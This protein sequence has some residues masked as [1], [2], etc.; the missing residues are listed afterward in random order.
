ML[1]HAIYPTGD[2]DTGV[3]A[4]FKINF[5]TAHTAYQE[6]CRITKGE[7]VGTSYLYYDYDYLIVG[8]FVSEDYVEG[9]YPSALILENTYKALDHFTR[10]N[11][12]GN[13]L[14]MP[15]I[16]SGGFYIPWKQT[17]A[18]LKKFNQTYIIYIKNTDDLG[19][20]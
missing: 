12:E 6:H 16:N 11:G 5:P 4:K 1:C 20:R 14:H 7:L 10:E 2:W 18:V 8:L 13:T 17:E 3:A 9:M 19:I 15:K